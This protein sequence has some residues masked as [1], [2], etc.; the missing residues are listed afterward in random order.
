MVSKKIRN[1]II[2]SISV[3]I[4]TAIV[5]AFSFIV[6]YTPN[7]NSQ[8]N[9]KV[10]RVLGSVTINIKDAENGAPYSYFTFEHTTDEWKEH[11]FVNKNLLFK[12]DEGKITV[13][14]VVHSMGYYKT[15]LHLELSG[16]G[17]NAKMEV[18]IN[19]VKSEMFTD[20]V[21]EPNEIKTISFVV[22]KEDIEKPIRSKFNINFTLTRY[23]EPEINEPEQPEGTEPE[24][25]EGG[26][27]PEGTEPET[28]VVPEPSEP[29][30]EEPTE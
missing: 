5:V 19:N 17:D 27:V 4:L 30:P 9:L 6:L 8:I 24:Q 12:G 23:V 7:M 26:E 1:T 29:T 21:F 15:N 16:P 10:Q 28:P 20:L 18:L 14:F 3:F 22:C 11:S 25:P 13:E 2:L